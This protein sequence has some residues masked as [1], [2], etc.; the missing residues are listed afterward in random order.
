MTKQAAERRAEHMNDA[1]HFG[2]RAASLGAIIRNSTS[3]N[4]GPERNPIS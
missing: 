2:G 1:Q 4:D 3:A